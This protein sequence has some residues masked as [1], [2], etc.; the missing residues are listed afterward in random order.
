M[1]EKVEVLKRERVF[2]EAI[3]RI[4]RVTLRHERYDG[5]MS[6]PQIELN[7]DRGDSA[8]AVVHNR[9]KG[10]VLLIEQFRYA[11]V[12]ND[13]GWLHEIP[14]GMVENGEDPAGTIIREVA[15]ETGYRIESL[16]F[17]GSFY[18]SPGGTSE[19]IHL[20]YAPVRSADHTESGGGRRE[21]G[22]D[23]R[24]LEEP[25]ETVYQRLDRGEI[26]D[27]KTLI[28]LQWL[29]LRRD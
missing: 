16:R 14:A 11:T 9:D 21:E 20:F 15:E 7:L 26:K 2:D 10:T 18:L 3:F 6:E 1:P 13:S 17:I 25:L 28:G 23:I 5:T 29:R 22:E 8:A 24:L 19:R 27:A 12:E 4:E